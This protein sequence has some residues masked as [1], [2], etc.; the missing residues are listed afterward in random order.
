MWLS[1]AVLLPVGIFLTYKAVTDSALFNPENYEK[2]WNRLVQKFK[3]L[4]D[5]LSG[6]KMKN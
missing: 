2:I 5:K 4:T 1:S 3:V 6:L